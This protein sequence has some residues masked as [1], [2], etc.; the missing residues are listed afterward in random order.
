M[1]QVPE[2]IPVPVPVSSPFPVHLPTPV[3]HQENLQG[4]GQGNLQGSSYVQFLQNL[5]DSLNLP[6]AYPLISRK[7]LKVPKPIVKQLLDPHEVPKLYSGQK[8]LPI[9]KEHQQVVADDRLPM[10]FKVGVPGPFP[11]ENDHLQL[12]KPY[13]VP[14]KVH[15]ENPYTIHL[16]KSIPLALKERIPFIIRVPLKPKENDE[17]SEAR[18]SKKYE[19]VPTERQTLI[20]R[21][22]WV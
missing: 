4:N 6:M 7:K 21:L 11:I 22:S 9:Q 1:L 15:V 12:E 18:H 17:W 13:S 10:L 16:D 2:N 8:R 3:E 19:N 5:Y 20:K 14:V